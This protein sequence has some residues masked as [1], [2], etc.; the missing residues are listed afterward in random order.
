MLK[1]TSVWLTVGTVSGLIVWAGP[2]AVQ[3]E[4][5]TIGLRP[6]EPEAMFKDGVCRSPCGLT[7]VDFSYL[8]LSG[9]DLNK[10]DLRFS[11]FYQT[12][13]QAANL[14]QAR[15]SFLGMFNTNLSQANLSGAVFEVYDEWPMTPHGVGTT[16]FVLNQIDLSSADL[17]GADLS[18]IVV[19]ENVNWLGARY[20]EQTRFPSGFDPLVAGMVLEAPNPAPNSASVRVTQTSRDSVRVPEASTVLALVLI[21][22][23][24]G[25]KRLVG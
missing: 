7:S 18:G 22:G 11:G 9:Y 19:G 3:V 12:N 13:L 14:S 10:A 25:L 16:P 17:S 21:G 8:D 23:G 2:A 20:T 24:F 5:A 15:F 6:F 1:R 4:A